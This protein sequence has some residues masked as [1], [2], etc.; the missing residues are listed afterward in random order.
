MAGNNG[1]ARSTRR[2]LSLIFMVLGAILLLLVPAMLVVLAFSQARDVRLPGTV[3]ILSAVM[4]MAF[5]VVG[6]ALRD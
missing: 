2:M 5:V 1:S 6:A 3:V 4:G